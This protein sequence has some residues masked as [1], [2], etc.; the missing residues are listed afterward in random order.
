M[1]VFIIIVDIKLAA[2]CS[3][4]L[5]AGVGDPVN[6]SVVHGSP[7]ETNQVEKAKWS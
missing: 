7:V 2:A 6:Q 1:F 5:T 4:F 3:A